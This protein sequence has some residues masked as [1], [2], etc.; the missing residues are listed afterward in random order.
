MVHSGIYEE[1]N[2][3]KHGTLPRKYCIS[4]KKKDIM[5][6]FEPCD[7]GYDVSSTINVYNKEERVLISLLRSILKAN[8]SPVTCFRY[9]RERNRLNGFFFISMYVLPLN[10]SV[11]RG[12]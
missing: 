11:A 12:H 2:D 1:S 10:P 8:Y 4:G 7:A 5:N 3:P 9:T 6:L